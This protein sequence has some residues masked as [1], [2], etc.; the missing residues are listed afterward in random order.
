MRTKINQIMIRT[1]PVDS[2]T[3]DIQRAFVGLGMHVDWLVGQSGESSVHVEYRGSDSWVPEN[4]VADKVM[5]KTFP[6]DNRFDQPLDL[7]SGPHGGVGVLIRDEYLTPADTRLLWVEFGASYKHSPPSPIYRVHPHPEVDFQLILF[8]VGATG[9]DILSLPGADEA[10][11][12][13]RLASRLGRGNAV[14]LG[15]DDDNEPLTETPVTA[16]QDARH[17]DNPLIGAISG[18]IKRAKG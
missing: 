3:H 15:E 18:L 16:H 14:S 6:W 5:F 8:P 17:T 11:I 13:E 2:F 10:K 4:K 12:D 7:N 9:C 1:Q